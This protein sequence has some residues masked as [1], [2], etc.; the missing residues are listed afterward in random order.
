VSH[1]KVGDVR[2]ARGDLGGALGSYEAGLA[3]REQLAA[4]DRSNTEWQRDLIVSNL[5]L[6]EVAT[7]GDDAATAAGRYRAALA[8]AER[9]EE[10]GRLAPRDAWLPGE[11]R[12]RLAAV[13]G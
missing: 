1:N 10:A 13:G 2:V 8:V 5:K 9:L 12:R 7:A 4:A 6:A 11:L 3:I